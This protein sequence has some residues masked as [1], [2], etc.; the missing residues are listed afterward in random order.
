MFMP[1][2]RQHRTTV[3]TTSKV[4]EFTIN[5]LRKL[6]SRVSISTLAAVLSLAILCMIGSKSRR[7]ASTGVSLG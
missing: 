5:L 3:L 4:A 6:A 7:L 2:T 1:P